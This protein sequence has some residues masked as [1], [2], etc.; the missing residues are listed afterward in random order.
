MTDREKV[1]ALL[2]QLYDIM[3]ERLNFFDTQRFIR[4]AKSTMLNLL[5]RGY[6]DEARD[7][8]KRLKRQLRFWQDENIEWLPGDW[9]KAF[10]RNKESLHHAA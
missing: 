7:M 2:K 5:N 8:A 4:S 6:V 1:N 9:Y 10:S 3:P